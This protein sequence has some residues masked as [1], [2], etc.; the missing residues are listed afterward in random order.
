MIDGLIPNRY[1]RALY[2]YALEKG[3]AAEVYDLMKIVIKSFQDNPDLQKVLSNPFVKAADKEKLLMAAA[4]E[5]AGDDYRRFIHLVIGHRREAFAYMMML[6]FRDIYRTENHISQVVITTAARLPE[7]EIS[8]LKALVEKGFNGTTLE[9]EEKVNPEL[10]GGFVIDVD[11]VRMDASLSN[12][13][14]Q[15]RLN[16]IRSN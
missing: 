11:S 4:G 13:L 9:Y 10:I 15:I 7:G 1:A 12:E 6:A 8:K 16:L 14:E 2:K 3:N 5:K